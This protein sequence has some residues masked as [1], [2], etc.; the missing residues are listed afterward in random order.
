MFTK[1]GTNAHA[2]LYI[3]HE[4]HPAEFELIC[5]FLQ[6]GGKNGRDR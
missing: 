4:T 1:I 6:K 2:R 3:Y 5:L